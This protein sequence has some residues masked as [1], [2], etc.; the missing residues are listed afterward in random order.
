MSERV[1]LKH[2]GRIAVLQMRGAHRLG[3]LIDAAL[4]A[5]ISHSLTGLEAD[6]LVLCG[7]RQGFGWGPGPAHLP[8]A[9]EAAALAAL[10]HQIADLP[11][12]VVAAITGA[13]VGA[14]LELALAA[15]HRI[16]S[17]DGQVGMPD[18]LLGLPPGAGATQ[19]LP[20]LVGAEQA[21][22]LLLS[23]TPLGATEALR[24][25]L[26]DE[27]DGDTLAAALRGLRRG[28]PPRAARAAGPGPAIAAARAGLRGQ[29]L[30]AARAVID[31]V[32]AAMLLPPQAGF[33][34]ERAAYEDCREGEAAFGLRH[35]AWCRQ[36]ALRLCDAAASSVE[37]PRR[38]ALSGNLAHLA[39]AALSA[40][41]RVTLIESDAGAAVA[42]LHD[43]SARL[44]QRLTE[45]EQEEA[46]TRLTATTDV[47]A[48]GETELLLVGTETGLGEGAA[49]RLRPLPGPENPRLWALTGQK[50]RTVAMAQA[51]MRR[52][53]QMTLPVEVPTDAVLR[54]CL[55]AM[56]RLARNIP[57]A[58][59]A[60]AL[61]AR[62]LPPAMLVK[63]GENGP[64][65]DHLR[66]G[67]PP[68]AAYRE[69]TI[70]QAALAAMVNAAAHA[71][72]ADPALQPWM[73]D[74]AL[75]QGHGFPRW[76][77][78][79][80]AAADHAGLEP[81]LRALHMLGDRPAPLLQLMAAEGLR[82]GAMNAGRAFPVPVS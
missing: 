20:R 46:W 60:A 1:H 68:G 64:F 12:P 77:G 76:R 66:R 38:V 15:D 75:V 34:F 62:G 79:P 30:P 7:E 37:V 42:R 17:P 63:S 73:L 4:C 32:E 18:I 26:V 69:T 25:G 3:P 31:C 74:F 78:G 65:L 8:P 22:H 82:F 21:L 55:R 52:L 50:G 57:A 53:D 61:A 33:D 16:L 80:L 39:V 28:L 59:V 27:V 41:L 81:L 19:R 23:G 6:A 47:Q 71:L 72:Q 49:V 40:G 67:D 24:I 48:I 70:W 2:E 5:E 29:D 36:Q 14:G 35:T 54:A 11:F 58:E 43:L 56:N 45:A 51:L 44:E 10:C 13:A 9:E